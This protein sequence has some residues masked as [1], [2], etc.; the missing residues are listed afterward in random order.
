MAKN[1]TPRYLIIALILF[2]AISSL[3]PTWRHQR[4]SED[5]KEEMKIDGELENLESKVIRQGLD[6]KGGM[7]IVLE[8]DIP[9]LIT[10]LASFKDERLL[11]VIEKTRELSSNPSL[12]VF[13]IF[14][15]EVINNNIK[16]SR[17][18]HEYGASLEDIMSALREESDDAINRVLE[19]LQN[20]VDQFGYPQV[21]Q[22][23]LL[24]S[25]I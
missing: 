1:L 19:I 3:L 16:L 25:V 7:Y 12:D 17:Y 20:R 8:A 22:K 9:A 5:Q 4:L 15:N 10:N 18:Y 13:T 6:L 21:Y 24:T 14:K 11:K 23:H 2:W